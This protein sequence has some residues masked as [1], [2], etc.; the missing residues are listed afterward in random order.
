MLMTVVLIVD[1]DQAFVDS[2]KQVLADK[3]LNLTLDAA[4]SSEQTLARIET[5]PDVDVVI[6]G[7]NLPDMDGLETLRKIKQVKPLTEV[8]MLVEPGTFEQGIK[9]MKYGAF[10]CMDK[11][12]DIDD[13]VNKILNGNDKKN[14][15]ERKIVEAIAKNISLRRGD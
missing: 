8:I 12:F 9:C 6:M 3:D 13:L 1:D 11:K 5:K 2:L 15:Q 14:Q 4:Y 10:E 7:V